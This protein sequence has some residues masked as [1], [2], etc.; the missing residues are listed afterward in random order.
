MNKNRL[1]AFSDGVFAIVITLLILDVRFPASGTATLRGLQDMLPQ[2]LSFAL[3]FVIVGV[4]WV[5][6]HNMFHYI[7][8]ADRR[9]LWLN[10]LLLL[11]VVFVPFPAALLGQRPG[12]PVA[13]MLYGANLVLVN[14][15]GSVLWIYASSRH[16]LREPELTDALANLVVKVHAGP[17][18]VYGLGILMAAYATRMSLLLYALVP[19]FFILPNPWLDRKLAAASVGGKERPRTATARR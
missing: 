19:A 6:H 7:R 13:V 16:E 14:A 12:D 15:V 17:I 10:L 5:S 11:V 9:L 2:V 4:Y 18:L 8:A 1:E 3:S